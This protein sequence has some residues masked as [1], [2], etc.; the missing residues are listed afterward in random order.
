MIRDDLLRVQYEA[1]RQEILATQ[2]RDFQVISVGAVIIP[3]VNYLIQTKAEVLALALPLLVVI[4]VLFHLANTHAIV[5]IARYLADHVEKELD[6]TIG[7]EKWIHES[8]I[9]RGR[10][11]VDHRRPER[12]MRAAVTV[13]FGAY[14]VAATFFAAKYAFEKGG[15]TGTL[16]L[17]AFYSAVGILLAVYLWKN[18]PVDNQDEEQPSNP[19]PKD[20][21][22]KQ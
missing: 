13:L 21:D 16:V 4:V 6:P 15:L 2:H 18:L 5:R 7:W 10:R 11:K 19:E 12:F 22:T 17:L 9:S 14:F 8:N 3:A 1:L 20:K